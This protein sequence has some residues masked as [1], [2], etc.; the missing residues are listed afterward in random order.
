MTCVDVGANIG[1]FSILMASIAGKHGRVYAL[2]PFPE[3]YNLLLK[4]IHENHHDDVVVPLNKAAY[5]RTGRN[6]LY[7]TSDQA[8]TNYGG[9]FLARNHQS[10]VARCHDRLEI[11]Q[12]RLDDII[13]APSKVDVIKIDVEGA[14]PFVLE[15]M[16]EIMARDR[17]LIF[18]E[19]NTSCLRTISEVDPAELLGTLRDNGYKSLAITDF[20]ANN[21][22]D[23]R[24]QA[25]AGDI[26]VNLVCF[27][28]GP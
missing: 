11:E 10:I 5:H 12:V 6:W 23:F 24:Y 16:Q 15:G 28:Q 17:P 13:S 19:F 22:R 1:F 18:L 4:N 7:F 26:Q 8:N 14:E 21:D 9:M 2:E 27:P 25:A 20:L 3:N